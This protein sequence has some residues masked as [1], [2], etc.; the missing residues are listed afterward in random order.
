M[1][2][3]KFRGFSISKKEWVYGYL[4]IMPGIDLHYILTGKI[5][6]PGCVIEK[7]E[8]YPDSIGQYTELKD[9]SGKEICEGDIV[10]YE[11]TIDQRGDELAH[12]QIGE[13]VKDKGMTCFKG[14]T[15]QI[16][17]DEIKIHDSKFIFLSPEIYEV[18]GNVCE[19][20][21]LLEVE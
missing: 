10:K 7:Y 16:Y 20:L 9:K 2:E 5:S 6:I 15:K 21:E 1:R 13:I 19:N 12:I 11:G 14:K 18:I 17:K 8:V 4:W 3:I